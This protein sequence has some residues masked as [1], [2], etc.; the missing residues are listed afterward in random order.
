MALTIN[1]GCITVISGGTTKTFQVKEMTL[2]YDS[3]A[4][5]DS[6]RD[7]TGQMHIEWILSRTRKVN[8][9]LPPL[10]TDEV[11]SILNL[12]TGRIYTIKFRDPLGTKPTASDQYQTS[13][14]VY[15]SK[16]S[17]NLYNGRIQNGIWTDAK[18][19]AIDMKG[20]S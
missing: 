2:D 13:L 11:R 10:S 19:S 6:G 7:D 16:S 12:V 4:T 5:E 9:T 17:V 20:E 1:D 8:I 18:F 15:T 3:L 14:T